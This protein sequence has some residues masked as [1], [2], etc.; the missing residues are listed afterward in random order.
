DVTEQLRTSDVLDRLMK[1]SELVCSSLPDVR[2]GQ[3]KEPP[4][5]WQGSGAFDCLDR[6]GRV[7][8]AKNA[9]RFLRPKI[10]F[11]ELLDLQP[12]QI[13]RLANE[14]ALDQF[15]RDNSANAFDIEGAARSEKFN[16]PRR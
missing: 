3:C 5:K 16:A 1:T 10:Q 8:F 2:N 9:G 6:L 4:G 12:K 13:E 7:F 11:R 15:V 14:T